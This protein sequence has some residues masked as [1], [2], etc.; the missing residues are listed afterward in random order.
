MESVMTTPVRVTE[1]IADSLT[2]G[3]FTLRGDSRAEPVEIGD[4]LATGTVINGRYRV[5]R[6]LGRGGV[7]LGLR[8]CRRA[9]S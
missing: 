5:I 8:R 3:I 2:R 6:A 9:P 4:A 7:R 1:S